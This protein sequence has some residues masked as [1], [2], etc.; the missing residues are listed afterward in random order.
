MPTSWNSRQ[1]WID[2]SFQKL[3]KT[4]SLFIFGG[5]NYAKG[6]DLLALLPILRQNL[7]FV[8]LIVWYYHN[9]YGSRRF[10]SNRYELIAWFA[11]SPKYKFNL[12]AVRI[13]YDETTLQ[14]ILKINDCDPKM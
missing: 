7:H 1:Q 3:K 13:T 9:G 6:N 12:D 4:G 8:N 5:V 2:A 10:F 14:N 11:K